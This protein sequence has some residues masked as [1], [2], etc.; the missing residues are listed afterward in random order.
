MNRRNFIASV[1]AIALA[2]ATPVSS[3]AATIPQ[4][5]L[6]PIGIAQLLKRLPKE[7]L[8]AVLPLV[9][10]QMESRDVD[11]VKRDLRK[12]LFEQGIPVPA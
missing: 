11:E 6:L 12:V 7:H 1:G 10:K 4:D 2:G 3:L 8:P 5:R 9:V